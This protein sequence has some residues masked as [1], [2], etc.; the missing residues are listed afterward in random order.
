MTTPTGAVLVG[1][2][3]SPDSLLALAWA[4]QAAR[5]RRRPLRVLIAEEDLAQ[6]VART[7]G[8]PER[9]SALVADA[10]EHLGAGPSDDISVEPVVGPP[11]KTLVESASGASLL[12]LGALG[13]GRLSGLVIGSVSQR[14]CGHATCPVVV[15]R[16]SQNPHPDEVVVGVDAVGGSEHALAFAF[17]EASRTGFGL[18]AIHAGSGFAPR[19]GSMIESPLDELD[20]AVADHARRL[21]EALAGWKERYPDVL[22]RPRITRADPAGALVEASGEAAMV[23]VGSRGRGRLAGALLGSVSQAVLHG[24]RC[25]VVVA[26]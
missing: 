23:V 3:G 21:S 20:D 4:K 10:Y 17:D 26:R 15:V 5:G 8:A 13:H 1:Y 2:D 7:D 6:V 14:V 18:T 12:V 24:A 25:P 11:A 22:V 19:S 16:R 9:T